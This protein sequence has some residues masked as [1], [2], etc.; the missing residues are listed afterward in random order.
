MNRGVPVIVQTTEAQDFKITPQQLEDAVTE[1]TKAFVLN[2]PSNPTGMV[3]TKEELQA[4][5]DVC[6][7]HDLYIIADEIYYRL[8]YDGKKFVSVA[9][10]GEEIREHCIVINGA[11]KSYSMT[12]WRCGFAACGDKRVAKVM[13]NCLSHAMGNIGA[14]NQAA[15][16]EAML[17][18]QD[19][20]DEMRRVFEERRDYLVKRMNAV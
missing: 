17:G 15:M 18:P 13:T 5:A 2:N 19:S 6:V 3:Y 1:R 9:S 4:L 12:G 20:V 11:S 8:C 16:A 10:L 7:K 14:M